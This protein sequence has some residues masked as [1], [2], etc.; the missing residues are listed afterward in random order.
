MGKGEH[1]L[2]ERLATFF[3]TYHQLHCASFILLIMLFLNFTTFPVYKLFLTHRKRLYKSAP[4]GKNKIHHE[5]RT[6]LIK[7]FY[8]PLKRCFPRRLFQLDYCLHQMRLMFMTIGQHDKC[9]F[10]PYKFVFL[11]HE[12]QHS[13][14]STQGFCAYRFRNA[15]FLLLNLIIKRSILLVKKSILLLLILL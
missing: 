5:I 4:K 9:L 15:K 7:F 12:P 1:R 6:I 11:Q 10:I 13:S 2:I 8:T 3:L 14:W